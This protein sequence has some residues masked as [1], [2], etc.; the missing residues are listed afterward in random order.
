MTRITIE[1]DDDGKLVQ[2]ITNDDE[3]TEKQEPPI[4]DE[5][6]DIDEFLALARKME[7][8]ENQKKTPFPIKPVTAPY[9]PSSPYSSRGPCV[10]CS[11]PL[12][13]VGPFTCPYCGR[14]Y[15]GTGLT[16]VDRSTSDA[17]RHNI[18]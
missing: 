2:I 17:A 16:W 6:E 14:E 18:D 10:Y 4:V 1:F 12:G 3:V 15:R 13:I 8:L 9:T 5:D 11:R 7:L